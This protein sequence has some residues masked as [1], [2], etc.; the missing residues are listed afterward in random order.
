MEKRR[1]M[2]G[3]E[4]RRIRQMWDEAYRDRD[5]GSERRLVWNRLHYLLWSKMRSLANSQSIVLEAGCGVSVLMNSFALEGADAVGLDMSPV[6]LRKAHNLFKKPFLIEG[7]ISHLPFKDCSFDMVYNIGVI[8][9]FKDPKPVLKEMQRVLKL[10]GTI[11]VSVP[12]KLTLWT[13]GRLFKNFLSRLHLSEPWK[14]RYEKSYTRSELR[15]LFISAGLGEPKVSGCGALE[16]FY[17]TAYFSMNRPKA[18]IRLLYPLLSNKTASLWGT[19]QKLFAEIIEKKG[20]LGVMLVASS[21]VFG[22]RPV[23]S[24]E[25]ANAKPSKRG[26]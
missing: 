14:Y 17:I 12:N 11:V 3:P 9:H 5:E 24:S 25:A 23:H 1:L 19:I 26:N 21:Q 13:V 7:D 8:E 20:V 10:H 16:G 18:I 22:I 6:A 15:N 4:K 2:G